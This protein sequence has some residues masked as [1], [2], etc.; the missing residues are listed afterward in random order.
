MASGDYNTKLFQ[1][2]EKGR[3]MQNTIWELKNS[4]NEMCSSSEYLARINKSHFETLFK[5][6]NQETIAKVI[7]ISQF[8]PNQISEEDNMELME[9]ISEDE[10]KETLH[11][12]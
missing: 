11:S 10:L 3:K 12:F 9:D 5:A 8:F 1:S 7:Q 2:F 6:E 4:N